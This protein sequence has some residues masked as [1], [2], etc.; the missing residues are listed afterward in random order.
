[1]ERRILGG[2]GEK[3]S[4]LGFG[5]ILVMEEEPSRAADLV[6]EAV[7]RGINYF[8]V[9]PSYGN[10]EERLGPALAP[11]RGRVFLACKTGQRTRVGAEAEL[12][13]SLRNMRTDHFDLYQHHGVTAMAEVEQ[14]MGPGGA[15]EA[16]AAA[17]AEGLVRLLGFSAHSEEA[18]LAM[19]ERFS[20]DTLLFPVNW[21]AWYGWNF[22]PRIL[23]EAQAKGLGILALKAMARR[24]LGEGEVK[25]WPKAWYAPAETYEE[26][27]LGLRFTLS[28]PVTAAIVPGHAEFLHWGCRI[29]EGLTPL[30]PGEEQELRARAK[31]VTQPIFPE[32]HDV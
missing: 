18:A 14:I 27:A 32:N 2:T 13:Q 3:L 15:M 12:R 7:D 17:R 4:V 20:F 22:G 24:R 5:G 6:A 19:M 1:M 25:Q 30:T 28:R 10:A 8:D 11:Y 31:E 9:A 23:E 29:V 21:A 26:A 16:F